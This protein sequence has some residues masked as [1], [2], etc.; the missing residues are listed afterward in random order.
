VPY[1][2]EPITTYTSDPNVQELCKLV[3]TGEVSQRAAQSARPPQVRS[4]RGKRRICCILT[5]DEC[6]PG[7]QISGARTFQQT[8]FGARAAP[9]TDD[10]LAHSFCSNVLTTAAH[11][12][13]IFLLDLVFVENVLRGAGGRLKSAQSRLFQA[14]PRDANNGPTEII[15]HL[16]QDSVD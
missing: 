15:P 1:E 7:G 12:P 9:F 2:I 4:R 16:Q 6:R 5:M 3:G 10:R 14:S 8:A 11:T 13:I